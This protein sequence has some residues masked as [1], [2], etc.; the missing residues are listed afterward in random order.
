MP[1][2]SWIEGSQLQR[3]S[4]DEDCLLGRES[5][6]CTVAQPSDSSVSRRHASLTRVAG[7]WWLKDLGS[8]N[9]TRLNGLALNQPGGN[10]LADGDQIS[11]GDWQLTFTEGFPG[12]DGEVSLER[13][14]DLF[15][16]VRKAPDRI[17][18]L[19][20]GLELLQRSTEAIL[21]EAGAEPLIRSVL[22]EALKLLGADRGFVVMVEPDRRLRSVHRVGNVQDVTGL[23]RTVLDYVLVH[24]TG[25]AANQ[26]LSD[27]RFGGHSLMEMKR[28]PL[29]AVPLGGPDEAVGVLYVDREAGGRPFTR[30]D[31]ALF[32]AFVRQGSI[33]LRH[34]QLSQKAL[35]HAEMERELSRAR[36]A[37]QETD[38]RQSEV[39]A[40]MAGPLGWARALAGRTE[41]GEGILLQL[42][43]LEALLEATGSQARPG[44]VDHPV[45][46]PLKSLH[47]ALLELWKPLL[48]ALGCKLVAEE[49]PES[50]AWMAR[51]HGILALE[52]LAEPLMQ[53]LAPGSEARL[54]WREEDRGWQLDLHLPGLTKAPVPDPWALRRLRDCGMAWR[55]EAGVLSVIFQ[56]EADTPHPEES[57]PAL[58][59]VACGEDLQDLFQVVADAHGL[60][61]STLGPEPPTGTVPPHRILVLDA[62]NTRDP[63]AI[64][65]SY[66]RHAAFAAV[67]ILVV[68]ALEE[69]VP[70][71]L[72]AGATDWL[73]DGFRWEALHHRLQ[74]LRGHEELQ[75]KALAA[76]RLDSFRQM[77]GTL[78]HE[79]NNPL[80]VISMQVEMLAMKYPEEPRLKKIEEM[81]ERIQGLL[82]VL[83]KMREATPE[84]YAD[85]SKIL[86]L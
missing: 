56:R 25:V 46:E 79:I 38:L 20:R 59:M 28:G 80:A 19:L 70:E 55:W 34:T 40:A 85:G 66:R 65:R 45:A 29:M 61:L 36:A 5:A 62:W 75:E 43:R 54:A 33:A 39:R 49:P 82:Q 48:E 76:E 2:L 1:F 71:L 30:F 11:L 8:R 74:V 73:P 83:Q 52:T 86:K 35:G 42:D 51:G 18:T 16:E 58:G 50:T 21:Q 53:R 24:R 9:G 4:L 6:S 13:V 14:G 3:H 60:S 47:E 23:S 17:A 15:D 64:I 72:H 69:Q 27:P 7:A 12:L 10:R 78:K 67:P 63:M 44:A 32:D 81:V 22:T 57:G 77:A 31:L 84:A 41:G 37:W 26:P 68:R